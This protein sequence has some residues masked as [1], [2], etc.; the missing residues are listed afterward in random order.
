MALYESTVAGM[1]VVEVTL[2]RVRELRNGR[3]GGADR[4]CGSKQGV[5]STQWHRP[6]LYDSFFPRPLKQAAE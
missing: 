3:D 2:D 1:A 4:V 5:L 6:E